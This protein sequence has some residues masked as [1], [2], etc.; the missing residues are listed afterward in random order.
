MNINNKSI[1]P[2]EILQIVKDVT[3]QI[4]ALFGADNFLVLFPRPDFR[5]FGYIPQLFFIKPKNELITRTYTTT[6]SKRPVI[7]YYN[8]KSE[9][10]SYNPTMIGENISLSGAVLTS[11]YK[12]ML[13][14][15]KMTPFGNSMLRFDV[16][17]AKEQLANRL[18][19]QVPFSVY[20]PTFGL[21]E[22]AIITSLTFKDTPFIDEIEVSLSMEIVKTFTLEKYKG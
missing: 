2:G 15:L 22:L 19:A 5:G 13:S 3:T 16:H 7:N 9:H 14:M 21:K 8:R 4:F 17:F 11:L 10:V 12:E 1:S 6:Y 18:Q 20:S